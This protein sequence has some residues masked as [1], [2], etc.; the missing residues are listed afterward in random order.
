MKWLVLSV[1]ILLASVIGVLKGEKDVE[2]G[3]SPTSDMDFTL[4]IGRNGA[5]HA[6]GATQLS[7]SRTKD[8]PGTIPGPTIRVTQG[9]NVKVKVQNTRTLPSTTVHWHGI[10]QATTPYSDGVPGVGQCPIPLNDTLEYNF[11]ATDP[12]SYFYHGHFSGQLV[13]GTTSHIT[14]HTS[15]ITH[16]TTPEHHNTT[17]H[18]TT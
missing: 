4:L 9:D 8:E 15:H 14:H 12:G 13:D 17:R 6:G 5:T 2:E 1:W 7:T 10:F 11:V 18:N 16:I 3:S